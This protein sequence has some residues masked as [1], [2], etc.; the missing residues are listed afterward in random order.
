MK[1]LG[2]QLVIPPF[3]LLRQSPTVS[4]KNPPRTRRWVKNLRFDFRL[5][6]PDRPAKLS[7]SA[8]LAANFGTIA[9]L[10][11]QVSGQVWGEIH[12]HQQTNTIRR[13]DSQIEIQV[14][15]LLRIG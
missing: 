7:S 6:P 9:P 14:T 1:R 5:L 4:Q 10:V 2:L 3:L 8:H 13:P 12:E 11:S 15:K